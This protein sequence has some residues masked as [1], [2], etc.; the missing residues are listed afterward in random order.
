MNTKFATLGA[1]ALIVVTFVA[2]NMIA[3]AGLR[4]ARFDATEGNLFTLTKG[5]KNIAKL[6][7]EPIDLTFYFSRKLAQGSPAF[8][9]YGTRVREMLEEY[10]RA[11][12]G[13][14]RLRVVEPEPFSDDEDAALAA[15]L[16]GLPAGPSGENLYFGLAGTNTIDTREKIAFFDPQ[17][18]AF[19]EYD[20][21]RMIY[22]LANPKKP[23]V[24]LITSLPMSGGFTMDP[25]TRQPVQTEPWR[26]MTELDGVF[27]VRPIEASATSIPADVGVLWI[28]HPKNLSESMVY[29][30]DQF[31]L[32]GGRALIF[33]DPL[34][35]ND[36]EGGPTNPTGSRT[37]N[38]P[39]LFNA[40]GIE[41][42]PDRL[43][44]DREFAVRVT[45]PGQNREAIPYV[46]W[47]QITEKTIDRGDA[48]TGQ[49]SRLTIATSGAWRNIAATPTD[50][51][52]PVPNIAAPSGSAAT[53]TPLVTTSNDSMLMPASAIG[54]QPDPKSLLNAFVKGDVPLTLVARVS[55]NVKSAFPNG[56]PAPA[57]DAEAPATPDA[58]HVAESKTPINVIVVADADCLADTFWSR[59]E[60][61]FGQIVGYRKFADNGDFT[62]NALDNLSGSSDLI[63]IRARDVAAR[64]FTL[65]DRMRR[66]AE[67]VYLAEQQVLQTKL[68]DTQ[69]K[70][71]ELQSAR[72]DSPEA[73]VL[74]PEQEAE[75]EKFQ[76]ELVAT[77][78]QLRDVQFNLNR[79]IESLGTRLK[80][81]NIGAMPVLLAAGAFLVAGWR[82]SRRR[83]SRA[84]ATSTQ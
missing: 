49:L 19:L 70:I 77:R 67:S 52:A 75:V 44:A 5:S 63:A 82:A 83:V 34:C 9:S 56:K 72:G 41:M 35:E 8:S 61:F 66:D 57:P 28:V 3:S 10:E 65:V 12:D 25:R 4:G 76:A 30:I 22:T 17:K 73:I 36:V 2:V 16:T 27:E 42:V 7:D 1:I 32:N 64:P 18:E 38:L 31:I 24:G 51:G 46:A 50:A 13:K 62:A 43:A 79:D 68:A 39:K 81:V 84:A 15:G 23:V 26:I 60:N 14:V 40:W 59:P 74:S 80:L 71:R 47:M 69:A 55:G 33:V 54:L 21:S 20:I 78:K 6:P 11:S 37:S 58:P 53:L 48:V 29:S 45:L